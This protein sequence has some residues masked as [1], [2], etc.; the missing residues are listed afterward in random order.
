ML[1]KEIHDSL[2]SYSV[3]ELELLNTKDKIN[4]VFKNHFHRHFF[5][6]EYIFIEKQ[7]RFISAPLHSHDFIELVYV[8]QGEMK[9]IVNNKNIILKQGEI[10]LLNQFAKHKIEAAEENDIILNFIISPDF[11]SRLLTLFDG[12]NKITEFV[13]AS[14]N[15]Q[16]RHGE[17]IHFKVGDNLN[18]QQSIFN[19]VEEVFGSS[20]LK[21]I[22]VHCLLGLLVTELLDN[23]ECSDYFVSM[24][25]NESVA[26]SVLRYIEENYR[27][28][29]LK[30]ISNRLNMPNYRISKLLK[31]F[32]GKTFSD[33][34]VDK[35]LEKIAYLLKNT[36]YPVV[37]VI[38]MC[39]YENASHCYK[40]FKYKYDL[41]PKCYRDQF[42]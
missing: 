35:K 12:D 28:A 15:S 30:E 13:L 19:L 7:T 16:R 14:I 2:M 25:Y 29:S 32:S 8:Y 24:N 9:Q 6:D 38:N 27:D 11:F 1:R 37:D 5:Q 31:E 42:N 3:R 18:I 26:V 23:M 39:G 40:L 17:H 34:L 20:M 36:E 4:H 33:I 10:L 41:S 21:Q 22:R